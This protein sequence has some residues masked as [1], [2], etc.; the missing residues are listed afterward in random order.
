MG[1]GLIILLVL[2]F[3]AALVGTLFAFKQEENKM[4][5]YE[6]AGDSVE[7]QLRRSHEY[8]TVSLKSNLPLQ[9][10]IY[11]VTIVLSLVVFAFYIF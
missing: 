7:D 2:L 4:K 8:E 3:T 6:E 9:V 1:M 10:A 11:S 5:H